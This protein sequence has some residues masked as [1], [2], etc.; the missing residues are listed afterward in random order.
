MQFSRVVAVIALLAGCA[1]PGTRP[2][3]MSAAAHDAAAAGAAAAASDHLSRST[4][5]TARYSE[6]CLG[7]TAINGPRIPCWTSQGNPAGRH[8][9]EA[10]TQRRTAA[11]HR[12]AAQAL[13][14]AEARACSSVQPDDRDMSPF[15]HREDIA[16]VTQI[17]GGASIAFRPV[18]GLTREGLQAI[19]DCH[20]ARSAALGFDVPEMSYCPLV[21]RGATAAVRV[22]GPTLVTDVRSDDSNGAAEIQRR[23][24]LLVV[25]TTE[26]YGQPG[27]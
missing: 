6:G 10:E 9:E 1:S 3:D 16:S 25:T 22:Q 26:L 17:P 5:G 14:D 13:R 27:R 18:A 4:P 19:V 7:A 15:F 12:A 11:S 8:I 24:R 2:S 20:L 23:A 21:P